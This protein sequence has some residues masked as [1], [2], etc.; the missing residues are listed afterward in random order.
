VIPFGSL[1]GAIPQEL[2]NT[3]TLAS[4]LAVEA[5]WRGLTL[6][7]DVHYDVNNLELSWWQGRSRHRI[8]F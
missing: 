4:I 1:I 2:P 3:S 7:H 6:A 8:D 5:A